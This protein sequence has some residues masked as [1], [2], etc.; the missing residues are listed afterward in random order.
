MSTALCRATIKLLC[1][2]HGTAVATTRMR[3]QEHHTLFP[4]A[5]Y[6]DKQLFKDTRFKVLWASVRG[7]WLLCSS[8]HG[9]WP[10]ST[11]WTCSAR[12]WPGALCVRPT[13]AE[14][15]AAQHVR[16]HVWGDCR[17]FVV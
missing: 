1:D 14:A 17:W 5:G 6:S 9:A 12:S 16:G 10:P 4:K 13:S 7:V 15:N 11:A 3:L 8:M 2:S